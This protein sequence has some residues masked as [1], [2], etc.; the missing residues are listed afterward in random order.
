[1]E[2]KDPL[3]SDKYTCNDFNWGKSLG[4]GKTTNKPIINNLYS[5]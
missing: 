4:E 3:Y 2:S 5:F 1:M